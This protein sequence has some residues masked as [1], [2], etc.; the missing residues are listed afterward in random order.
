MLTFVDF[1]QRA[2]PNV[3]DIVWYTPVAGQRPQKQARRQQPLLGNNF[4]NT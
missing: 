2:L 1:Q 4:V 3:Y